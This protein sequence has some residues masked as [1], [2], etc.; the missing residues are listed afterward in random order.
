[1]KDLDDEHTL[2]VA[3]KL[4]R[5]GLIN[6]ACVVGNLKPAELR[7]RGA[8]GTL[9]CLGLSDIPVGVGGV[10][11]DG[12]SYP[13]EAEVP[14]LADA[15]EVVQDGLG[16]MRQTLTDSEDWNTILVLQS[17]L[18]DALELFKPKPS[19]FI[20]KISQ[21]AIMGGVETDGD[22]LK[23]DEFDRLFP[24]NANN[25]MFD[26]GSAVRLYVALQ[27]FGVPMV[28]TTRDAAY[29]CQVPF[30]M[31][32]LMEATGNPVG[33]CLK[34]RQ[35]PALQKLWEA[36]C[37]ASGSEIRGTLPADRNRQW[38][39]TVFCNGK[40]PGIS[41][42]ENIWPYVGNFNLYDPINFVAAIPEL[43]ARF[44][45][46]VRVKV[47]NTTHLL[48]GVS[49]NRHGIKDVDQ[50]RQFM[51]SSEV[52]ALRLADSPAR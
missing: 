6:L 39:I 35:L 41:D 52:E 50:L 49:R 29:S 20:Q 18:T 10:V 15:S 7:A 22:A 3:A 45:S 2:C 28:I 40:D 34:G 38:F 27:E 44:F 47:G 8:K 23:L 36:A 24:N 32:D 43:R 11:F 16:L 25:N 21:V 42:G 46:P 12:Q 17:G 26:W 51:I 13:Y 4:H 19:L 31:Y 37:S 1:M 14:Y 48:I 5:D 30:S 33:A 9:K